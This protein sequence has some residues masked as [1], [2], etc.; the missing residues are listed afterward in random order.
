MDRTR[1]VTVDTKIPRRGNRASGNDVK[2]VGLVLER[3]LV[4]TSVGTTLSVLHM[5]SRLL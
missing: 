1:E 5:I 2:G 4:W 3:E